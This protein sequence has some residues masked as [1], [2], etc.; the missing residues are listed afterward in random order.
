MMGF[1]RSP[2]GA[3]HA[4]PPPTPLDQLAATAAALERARSERDHA[5]STA[6]GRG[7]PL[8]DI[9]AA[10]GLSV[11]RI[12]QIAPK[13]TAYRSVLQPPVT[14][15]DF[16]G[17]LANDQSDPHGERVLGLQDLNP[18]V[19]EW[20]SE[21]AFVD[22][23]PS[24]RHFMDVLRDVHDL[25][26]NEDWNLC[27]IQATQELYAWTLR[28][29]DPNYEMVGVGA[30]NS[31]PC[32]LLGHVA[33]WPLVEAGIVRPGR[34]LAHRLGGLAWVYGRVLLLNRITRVMATDI[35][36]GEEH[37]L[38]YLERLPENENGY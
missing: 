34:N 30:N 20:A 23:D 36:L 11:S 22:A 35:G 7:V 1:G 6:R 10:A 14:E 27:Y 32:I 17:A 21:M 5:I 13:A 15:M 26:E 4:T 28:T 3:P 12:K 24:R 31:G 38:E 8:R 16:L 2:G 25:D 29:T 9:A 18:F 33:S 37:V 19:Q